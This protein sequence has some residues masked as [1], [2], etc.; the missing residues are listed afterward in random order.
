M[1]V[2]DEKV[3]DRFR[4]PGKCEWC[5]H[6]R[7]RLDAAHIFTRGAGR[8]DLP[9]NLVGLCHWCHVCHH[10]GATPTRAQL[11]VVAAIREGWPPDAMESCIHYLRD[12]LDKD[13]E[14]IK[15]ISIDPFSFE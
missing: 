14:P 11:L 7:K 3:L 9:I 1:N 10:N 15:R 6:L 4:G 5:G 8:L 13:G 2:V 12:Q